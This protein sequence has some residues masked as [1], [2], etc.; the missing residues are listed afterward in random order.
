MLNFSFLGAEDNSDNKIPGFTISW[1]NYILAG[2]L[3]T[4]LLF[5]KKAVT[6]LLKAMPPQAV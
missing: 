1:R 3:P 5:T 2:F 4:A 6:R